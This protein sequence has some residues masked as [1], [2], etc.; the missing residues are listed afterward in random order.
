MN[1]S[2]VLFLSPILNLGRFGILNIATNMCA[3]VAGIYIF[4]TNKPSEGLF[5]RSLSGAATIRERCPSSCFSYFIKRDSDFNKLFYLFWFI[6]RYTYT[7]WLAFV[8]LTGL[9]TSRW[10]IKTPTVMMVSLY[11]TLRRFHFSKRFKQTAA[12]RWYI[13]WTM[14]GEFRTRV[15]RDL[16]YILLTAYILAIRGVVQFRKDF[17]E[18]A[19][20]ISKKWWV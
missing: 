10:K 20:R 1:C 2:T 12:L 6:I 5:F 8:N 9:S 4:F 13:G 14:E 3:I 11:P 19:I 7:W 15:F 18:N 16:S 17:S